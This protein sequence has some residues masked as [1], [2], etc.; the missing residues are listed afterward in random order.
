MKSK[1][2]EIVLLWWY[3]ISVTIVLSHDYEHDLTETFQVICRW[4]QL[5]YVDIPHDQGDN[6]Y[7]PSSN[8]PFGFTR[9]PQSRRIFVGVNRRNFGI[10]STLNYFYE[11][12][13]YS[14][15]N[16]KLRP[17][18]DYATN[19]IQ[20]NADPEKI[21]SIYRP[22]VDSCN[23]LWFVDTGVLEYPETNRKVVNTPSI[24]IMDLYTDTLIR[25]FTIPDGLYRTD[26]SGFVNIH[27]EIDGQDC[28][29]AHAY[30]S[31]YI[32]H[33][34]LV[35]SFG[36]NDAW[37]VHHPFMDPVPGLQNMMLDGISI[38]FT[39]GIFPIALSPPGSEDRLLF[40]TPF[41]S[42]EEYV[43]PTRILKDRSL[44][45]NNYDPSDFI[46]LGSKGSDSQAPVQEINSVGV[47]FYPE[48]QKKN[49]KC[50]NTRMPLTPE[51]TAVVYQ[52]NQT[53]VYGTYVE[54]D[55]N[56]NIWVMSDKFPIFFYRGLDMNDYNFYI[57]RGRSNV[58][59]NTVCSPE[60]SY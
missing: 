50:W 23:R 45:P 32:T 8:V 33:N 48:A 44:F 1:L 43:V 40:F 35:Y 22:K 10:P 17:Y 2:C 58:V 9:A 18:P 19:S 16:P 47:M 51:N 26:G 28:D 31:N 59:R 20:Y 14:E 6:F 30:V 49:I 12:E 42:Y 29:N 46:H 3:L 57:V 55:E 15:G 4:K 13:C 53:M 5:E 24:W 60:Y 56:D 39:D 34:L 25:R 38:N 52:N 36:A 21:V 37:N 11:N 27:V 54:I 41:S 7:V